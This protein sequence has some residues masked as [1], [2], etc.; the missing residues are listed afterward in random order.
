MEDSDHSIAES[1]SAPLLPEHGT[2]EHIIKTTTSSTE[3]ATE[4]SPGPEQLDLHKRPEESAG[5]GEFSLQSHTSVQ[6]VKTRAKPKREPC[7]VTCV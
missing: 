7:D 1:S 4:I 2:G 5:A 3:M 6:S